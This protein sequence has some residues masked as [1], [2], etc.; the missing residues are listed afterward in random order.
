MLQL[1]PIRYCILKSPLAILPGTLNNALAL[2]E[3]FKVGTPA[4][5][6]AEAGLSSSDYHIGL[7][8]SALVCPVDPLAPLTGRPENSRQRPARVPLL[9]T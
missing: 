8:L 4:E 2:S 5:K 7:L 3:A 9:R 1:G 6:A